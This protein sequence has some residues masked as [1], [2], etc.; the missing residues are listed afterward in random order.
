MLTPWLVLFLLGA[1]IAGAGYVR[2]RRFM[3]PSVVLPLIYVYWIGGPAVVHLSGWGPV[4]GLR[5]E[6]LSDA[7]WV[8]SVALFAVSAPLL[9]G[10]ARP[11]SVRHR[12]EAPAS[13]TVSPG[14]QWLGA[15]LT[16][17][18]LG[19][20]GWFGLLEGT[21]VERLP[22]T[23]ILVSVHYNY[24]MAFFA[25][26]TSVCALYGFRVLRRSLPVLLSGGV[27]LLYCAVM[28]ERD[29]VLVFLM[30]L[31]TLDLEGKSVRARW[32]A[33]GV[34]LGA[35][36]FVGMFW[37][38]VEVAGESLDLWSAVLGQ[39]SSLQVITNVLAWRE[40]GL[41]LEWG[42][43]YLYALMRAFFLEWMVRGEP[44]TI[45]YR[46]EYAFGSE[47]GYG[48]S[49]EAEALLN[50][51]FAGVPVVFGCL[52]WLLRTSYD[53][54]RTGCAWRRFLFLYSFPLVLAA[55]R[56]DSLM[57]A[58]GLVAGSAVFW[59]V[60][61][62]AGGRLLRISRVPRAISRDPAGV[63]SR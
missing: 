52:G 27:Y 42:A 33:A 18:G 40:G 60:W 15:L 24:L 35:I 53:N 23:P 17:A 13:T 12:A 55:L 41:P 14:V 51:G 31:G 54:A 19:V 50:W 4:R 32:V 63:A 46:S 21:K 9:L 34:G 57:L 11:P 7:W 3:H 58:R 45:W 25:F 10:G 16:V 37:W 62:A 49:L 26:L 6:Y 29:F 28:Q 5:P 56:N 22:Q 38:R 59:V 47:S 36:A 61:I 2:W 43:T 48:F 39:G 1:A 20:F 44:L 30:V 8:A